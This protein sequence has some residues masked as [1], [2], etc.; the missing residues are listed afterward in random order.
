MTV[1]THNLQGDQFLQH[2]GSMLH[3]SYPSINLHLD[4]LN[5]P[6]IPVPSSIYL[7]SGFSNTFWGMVT[8]HVHTM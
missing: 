5:F 2:E 6:Q 7:I 3:R 1:Q 8:L 4:Y